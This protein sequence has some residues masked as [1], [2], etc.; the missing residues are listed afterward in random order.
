MTNSLRIAMVIFACVI[1]LMILL[2]LKNKKIPVKY[3]I[4]W[5]GAAFI[6]L[7]LATFPDIFVLASKIL[8]FNMMSNM[9]IAVFIGI[10]LII[11]MVLTVIVS[12]QKKQVTMLIQE[13]SLLKQNNAGENK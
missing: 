3:S 2:F 1:I 10:L 5:F 9:I 11:T 6:I 12:N 8:G 7:F 13:V 4:V